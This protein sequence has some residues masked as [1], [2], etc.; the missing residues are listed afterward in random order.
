MR[1]VRF[2][3]NSG[4]NFIHDDYDDVIREQTTNKQTPKPWWYFF[5]SC[6]KF[7]KHKNFSSLM[8]VGWR[9]GSY[10]LSFGI[11]FFCCCC[12]SWILI[13][14]LL[15]CSIRC[16]VLLSLCVCVCVLSVHEIIFKEKID[17]QIFFY[18]I[19]FQNFGLFELFIFID[20][21]PATIVL[22]KHSI[23]NGLM[24]QIF[25]L[26]RIYIVFVFH[27]H[28]LLEH[29]QGMMMMII[30]IMYIEWRH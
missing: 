2:E 21:N 28:L 8:P 18:N 16:F 22:F 13:K 24:L 23:Y 4:K 20:I 10:Y 1:I 7:A 5:F 14:I 12:C 17:L 19:L 26:H 25:F 6:Q 30:I 15:F 27:F 11:I 29:F 9:R 3:K